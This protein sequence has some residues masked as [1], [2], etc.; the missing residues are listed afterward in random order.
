MTPRAELEA[1]IF[2]RTRGR[3]RTNRRWWIKA[4]AVHVGFAAIARK[5][6]QPG[7]AADHLAQARI[8]RRTAASYARWTTSLYTP[9]K[10]R[11]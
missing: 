1:R 11:K 2:R 10:N 4:A 9:R 8:C 7:E 6:G 3:R 5:M